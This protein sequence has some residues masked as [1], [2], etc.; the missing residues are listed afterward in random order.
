MVVPI[1]LSIIGETGMLPSVFGPPE[2]TMVLFVAD[3]GMVGVVALVC[4]ICLD[5]LSC[6]NVSGLTD[7][8]CWPCRGTVNL[9]GCPSNLPK[10]FLGHQCGNSSCRLQAL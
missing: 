3:I 6:H 5:Y 4:V 10:Y 8:T 7:W 9:M 2:F 1:C